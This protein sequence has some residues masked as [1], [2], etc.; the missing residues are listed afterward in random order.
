MD[1]LT[2]TLQST[3]G[4]ST[5]R[6][7]QEAIIRALLEGNDALVILPTGSGKSLCYQLPAIM[8]EGTTLVVSP[9]IALMKDQVD[10]LTARRIPAIALNSTC[11][12]EETTRLLRN[13]RMGRY[14]L[15]YV[16]PERFRNPRFLETLRDTPLAMLAIDEAHCISTWGH[17][18]RPDYL[19][20]K[21]IVAT[22]PPHIRILAVTAT[23]TEN[24]RQD[25]LTNLGLGQH[26]RP[27]PQHFITG[28]ARPNLSLNVTPVKSHLQKL[29]RLLQVIEFFHTGIIY[30]ATRKMV[31]RVRTLLLEHGIQA[32]TY[33]GAMEDHQRS[34]AQEAFMR[35]E[36]PV[37]IATNAFG[38]GVDRADIRFIVHWDI[39][40]S[41][42]AYYQEVGRAGRDGAFAWCELLYS[43]ADV[44]TQ[45]FF[46]ATA[47]PPPE[48]I[49]ELYAAIRNACHQSPTGAVTLS[50]EAWAEQAG[51]KSPTTVRHLLSLFE[52]KSL[53]LRTRAIGQPHPTISLPPHI[54][55]TQLQTICNEI[56]AKETADRARL[57]ELLAYVSTRVCRHRFLL[58]YFGDST[59]PTHCNKCNIC[60]PIHHFPPRLQPDPER[61]IQL[62]K[63]LSCI[64]R[65][66]G[67]G[68]PE[69]V[70]DILRGEAPT[71]YQHLTTY[72][73][74]TEHP[75]PTLLNIIY[76]LELDGY[77]L[78]MHL[79]PKGYDLVL[80]RTEVLPIALPLTTKQKS[81]PKPS[82]TPQPSPLPQEGLATALRKWVQHEAA[83]RGLPTYCILN[84][85]TLAEI[86]KRQPRDELSLSLIPGIGEIKLAKYG[87]A[88]LDL[89]NQYT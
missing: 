59:R 47:N 27:T 77:L 13:M 85:K 75:K 62:R 2:A 76:A 12:P 31:E 46:I 36:H 7:G 10:A 42:E 19:H 80:D 43:Y 72:G 41:I 26:G 89:I 56:A 1:Q 38:M 64:V 45:E 70:A 33:N 24:V 78:D 51:L 23:A 61:L 21:E 82:S 58:S 15:V 16:A 83:L 55:K 4:F 40:G 74:L 71:H 65:L 18:F 14:K 34:A 32:L 5:F 69:L 17:D 52:R 67:K 66:H 68:T 9:L 6:P 54:D 11:S 48:H 29:E 86:A 87:Q 50:P 57:D 63:I 49:Y 79:T 3:F 53:L 20:L 81:S 88:L 73:I 39:P 30:C 37:V 44:K 28:F 25:I 8:M 22:L 84:T 60:H 35:R